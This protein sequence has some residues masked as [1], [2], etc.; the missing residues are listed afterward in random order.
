MKYSEEQH[1]YAKSRAPNTA[2]QCY[3]QNLASKHRF[4]RCGLDITVPISTC[5]TMGP[6]PDQCAVLSMKGLRSLS[7][8]TTRQLLEGSFGIPVRTLHL[9]AVDTLPLGMVFFPGSCSS[10]DS[11]FSFH[12]WSGSAYSLYS[13]WSSGTLTRAILTDYA[14]ASSAADFFGSW[15][16]GDY[17]RFCSVTSPGRV[18]SDSLPAGM[19]LHEPLSSCSTPSL[20]AGTALDMARTITSSQAPETTEGPLVTS[21]PR[22]DGRTH[23][24]GSV[25]GRSSVS[26][27][28]LLG[29]FR[30]V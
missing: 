30:L 14:G 22:G 2:D 23:G 7:T 21:S 19:A 17:V 1:S 4:S 29:F 9:R 25:V 15:S 24:G 18:S 27:A 26:Q 28:R 16:F 13:Y 20:D 8:P 11:P 6:L 10:C 5:Y 12:G 3:F